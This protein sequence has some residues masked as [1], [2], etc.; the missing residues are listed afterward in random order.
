MQVQDCIFFNIAKAN[1]AATRF[2][3]KHIA[4]LSL[5]A[6]Q[7]MVLGFLYEEDSVTSRSLGDR[8]V[9][10]SATLTGVLDRLEALGLVERR[11][12]PADRRAILILLTDEG[13]KTAAEIAEIMR[14]ANREFLDV[15][16]PEEEKQLRKALIK[17]RES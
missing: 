8:T 11:V 10:D 16:P 14:S 9:L 4:R 13:R 7:G 2:W 12:H 6:V 5:T 1:Q 15:F 3:S 17:I